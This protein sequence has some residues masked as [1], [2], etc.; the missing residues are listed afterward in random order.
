MYISAREFLESWD[1]EIYEMT[2]LDFFI[3]LMV[4]HLGNQ[5]EKRFFVRERQSSSLCIDF[6]N[7]GTLCFN[8]GDSF[9][10][11]LEDEHSGK[12]SDKITWDLE[13]EYREN[14]EKA[15]SR[16]NK[17]L[18]SFLTEGA[19]KEQSFR[20]ELMESVILDTLVQFYYDEMGI[21]VDDEELKIIELADFIEDVMIEFIRQEGQTLLQRPGDPAIDYFEGLLE[22]ED[23]YDEEK[24]WN[25]DEEENFYP[26]DEAWEEYGGEYEDISEAIRKFVDDLNDEPSEAARIA[27][28]IEL[29]HEYLS[30]YAEISTLDDLEEEHFFEFLA[31]WLVQRFVHTEEPQFSHLFQT[32]A[33]F[34][35]WL[36]HNYRIDYKRSYLRYYDQLKTEVPR[37]IYC[38]NT[39][40]GEANLFEILLSREEEEALQKSGFYQVKRMRS[41]ITK[42]FDLENI[43]SFDIIDNVK[44]NSSVYS[45][46][47]AGDIL[48]ATITQKENR[49]EVAEIQYFYPHGARLFIE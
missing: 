14:S 43:H 22:S 44:L 18:K 20:V 21:E 45:R 38:L 48:Q 25:S 40:V 32:L 12:T 15:V 47:K 46:L 33:R 3:Y 39:Y 2:N 11:F 5:L 26:D 36:A 49:W 13:N 9:E 19:L 28:D 30:E 34:V 24:E 1:K 27:R 37:I 6:D 16:K 4:N 23:D 17:K 8:L 10:Y 42:S 41:R 29:F 7:I 35:T 31:V